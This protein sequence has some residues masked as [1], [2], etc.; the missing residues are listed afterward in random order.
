MNWFDVLLLAFALSIDACVVSF[1]YGIKGCCKNIL[2]SSL[3]LAIFTG[4]FQ[5][6]MPLLGGICTDCVRYYIEPYAKWIIFIIFLYLGINFIKESFGGKED[7]KD[8]TYPT[9]FLI[10]IATSIDAFSAGI[11]L[12]LKLNSI[13]LPV[14]LIGLVTF[15]NSLIGFFSGKTFKQFNP[16]CL[17]ILGG[18]ILIALA[19]KVV[20]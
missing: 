3:L 19:I 10:A 17:E 9:L 6:L 8:L 2:K 14:I 5:G 18:L 1:S 12:S 15:I 11:S 7:V 4:L 16:K 13:I 20:L